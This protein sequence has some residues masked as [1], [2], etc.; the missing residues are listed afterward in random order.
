[1]IENFGLQMDKE[2]KTSMIQ[3][4][5]VSSLG[6]AMVI[7]SAGGLL[8]G[9]YLDRKLGTGNKLA[10][11]FFLI[12]TTAGFRNVYYVIKKNFSDEKPII[13]RLKYEPH[14]RRPHPQKA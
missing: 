1:M 14:R 12:G 7:M 11:L 13:K 8:V 5:H 10:L 9:A 6:F 4:A 3:M 2:M